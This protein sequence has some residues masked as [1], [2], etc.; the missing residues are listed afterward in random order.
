[1]LFNLPFSLLKQQWK[2]SLFVIIFLPILIS[3]GLWQLD[4]AEQKQQALTVYQQR[5]EL[6]AISIEEL[7]LEK[8]QA[9]RPLRLEGS[10][11]AKHYWLLD[12]QARG[13]KVGYEVIM[14]FITNKGIILV[15]RGWVE[16]PLT[17]DQLPIVETTEQSLTLNGYLYEPQKN[18]VLSNTNSDLNIEWP[19]RVLQINIMDA[20]SILKTIHN[21]IPLIDTASMFVRI[22]ENNPGAFVTDWP[23][24][25]TQPEK[26]QGYAM[27]WFTMALALVLLYSW[28]LY[29]THQ[30]KTGVK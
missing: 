20:L 22:S 26:H 13:G 4:R 8:W 15:N 28:L 23:L 2:I 27:Q 21:D 12:N 29:R 9:Y 7:S 25:N 24:I 6:P 14:P 5:Q 10:Y 16:A 3:L 18:A 19:K 17:R 1:M 30:D 11:D